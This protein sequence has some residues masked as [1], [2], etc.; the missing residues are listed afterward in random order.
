MIVC[1]GFEP[2]STRWSGRGVE[3]AVDR[4]REPPSTNP[5]LM[6]VYSNLGVISWLVIKSEGY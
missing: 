1:G 6:K 3:C 4:P 2:R 5:P